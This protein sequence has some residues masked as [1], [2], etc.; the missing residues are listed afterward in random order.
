MKWLALPLTVLTKVVSNRE[1]QKSQ[2][3]HPCHRWKPTWVTF[4]FLIHSSHDKF[5]LWRIQRAVVKSSHHVCGF[6][7]EKSYITSMTLT[8]HTWTPGK[9]PTNVLS[10]KEG[11]LRT[12]VCLCHLVTFLNQ[13]HIFEWCVVECG[14]TNRHHSDTRSSIMGDNVPPHIQSDIETSAKSLGLTTTVQI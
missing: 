6:T 7:E 11:K 2:D 13:T 3:Q 14:S 8:V 9:T 12:K 4:V 1:W 10:V 5:L